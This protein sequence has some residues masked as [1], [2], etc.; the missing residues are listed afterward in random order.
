MTVET[1]TES[2]APSWR[3]SGC[4]TSTGNRVEVEAGRLGFAQ[5]WGRPHR[6]KPA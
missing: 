3:G 1:R 5:D 4:G 6:P 2:T